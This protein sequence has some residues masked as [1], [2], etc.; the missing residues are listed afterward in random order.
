MHAARS[1]SDQSIG[2]WLCRCWL[3]FAPAIAAGSFRRQTR[4][5]RASCSLHKRRCRRIMDL[6]AAV[7]FPCRAGRASL[8]RWT[9]SAAA[10]YYPQLGRKRS[11]VVGHHMMQKTRRRSVAAV[12]PYYC[13][14]FVLVRSGGG[15]DDDG[16]GFESAAFGR[17]LHLQQAGR[18]R[19]SV[20]R[21]RP[22]ASG[23]WRRRRV[24]NEGDGAGR[25]GRHGLCFA[26]DARPALWCLCTLHWWWT[27]GWIRLTCRW[28]A[29]LFIVLIHGLPGTAGDGGGGQRN[30]ATRMGMFDLWWWLSAVS[31][32]VRVFL[33]KNRKTIKVEVRTIMQIDTEAL[34][35]KYLGLPTALGR[36][37][38][39][40]FEYMPARLKKLVGA[41]SGKEASCAGREVLLKSVAQAVPTYLMSCASWLLK[42]RAGRWNQLS[43]TI[44]GEALLII[45][46]CIGKG[47]SYS[48]GPNL[49]EAWVFEIW[50]CLIWQ[51]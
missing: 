50:G 3:M 1:L 49:L 23:G 24:I 5:R 51:C 27:N 26:R 30:R 44:G 19:R 21:A 2:G 18:R 13:G 39:E 47:G 12:V 17:R 37:T 45:S 15:R 41:W 43:Q 31:C 35:E 48:L 10:T 28:H 38:K 36:S 14:G 22:E 32:I 33:H 42:T 20:R 34:A 16:D 4:R 9:K 25:R 8:R 46:I 40:A 7:I 6:A 11:P 29:S